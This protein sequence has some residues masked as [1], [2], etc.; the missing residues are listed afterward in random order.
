MSAFPCQSYS[1][2]L[3]EFAQA[4]ITGGWMTEAEITS[5]L[6]TK[7]ATL[8]S[9]TNI[10]T[11]NST[12]LLGSGD[13][14]I[15]GGGDVYLASANQFTNTNTFNGTPNASFPQRV[16][17]LQIVEGGIVQSGNGDTTGGGQPRVLHR[18][19]NSQTDSDAVGWGH[20]YTNS[21]AFTSSNGT[22]YRDHVFC[23]G[24]N[25]AGSQQRFDN[26]KSYMALQFESKFTNSNDASYGGEWHL[27]HIAPGAG[28]PT[29]RALSAFLPYD[30]TQRGLASFS[31]KFDTFLFVDQA[32]TTKMQWALNNNQL[33]LQ[34][35]T[36]LY[37]GN[38]RAV[39]KQQNAALGAYLDLPYYD[40]T[41]RIRLAAG[42]S[43]A[44]AVTSLHSGVGNVFQV[45]AWNANN[46]KAFQV[47]G[48]SDAVSG[49]KVYTGIESQA[50]INGKW[51][52][53]ISNTYSGGQAVH[54][55]V[56]AGSA[57][58]SFTQWYNSAT[59]G[60][61][62]GYN[63]ATEELLICRHFAFAN[64]SLTYASLTR[65][66]AVPAN[67]VWKL[68]GSQSFATVGKGVTYKS[69]T[70]Q[71]AGNATLVGGT[72]TVTNTSV[73]ANTVISINRKTAGGTIG[74]LT[75]TLSAGASFTI[76]SASASDT[77]VVSY[78]MVEVV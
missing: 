69:G 44:G 52:D 60:F 2:D 40:A 55:I 57:G 17:A 26:T 27:E 29:L 56:S 63:S 49:S 39:A 7:Q 5:A 70:G 19:N 8:V 71:R 23:C 59:G 76:N 75:Y 31:F 38:N 65:A 66:S 1:E 64:A 42:V 53:A 73:T 58:S 43:Q 36:E 62:V 3:D 16:G 68:F 47:V 18:F 24:I 41:N 10:K 30:L 37:D 50:S 25:V 67:S 11:V 46:D 34:S 78:H 13:I 54:Y 77:S 21:G 9:G 51:Q 48:A 35:L 6:S 22:S 15:S 20:I 45:T 28:S 33:L 72:V 4:I 12:S 32:G 61:D 14:A 74:D